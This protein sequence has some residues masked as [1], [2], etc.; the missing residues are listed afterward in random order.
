[1]SVRV[2]TFADTRHRGRT[3][4]GQLVHFRLQYFQNSV[5]RYKIEQKNIRYYKMPQLCCPSSDCRVGFGE[6]AVMAAA[7][8]RGGGAGFLH[9][10]GDTGV[11]LEEGRGR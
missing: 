3:C 10:R 6:L 9:A 7:W 5:V 8:E 2:S 11:L 4:E 1:M